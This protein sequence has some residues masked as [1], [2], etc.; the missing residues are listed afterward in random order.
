MGLRVDVTN[1]S[2]NSLYLVWSKCFPSGNYLFVFLVC[3]ILYV[4]I[5]MHCSQ[6]KKKQKWKNIVLTI[7]FK[8][9][10][11]W[12]NFVYLL[13]FIILLQ[14]FWSN[15]HLY[16]IN[17]IIVVGTRRWRTRSLTQNCSTRSTFYPECIL[18]GSLRLTFPVNSWTIF[19]ILCHRHLVIISQ[20]LL[21][22]E[23]FGKLHWSHRCHHL[24]W[25]NLDHTLSHIILWCC[26]SKLWKEKSCIYFSYSVHKLAAYFICTNVINTTEK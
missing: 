12:Q 9:T 17:S 4:H 19:Q 22:I 10:I 1:T 16:H 18:T 25:M 23:A 13:N 6:K 2:T 14:N 8:S 21:K 11:T 26:W 5:Q 24:S 7:I 3:L 15:Y 20:I